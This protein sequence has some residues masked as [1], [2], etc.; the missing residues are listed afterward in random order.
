MSSMDAHRAAAATPQ[1]AAA[2]TAY[3]TTAVGA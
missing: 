2:A 3:D 1:R